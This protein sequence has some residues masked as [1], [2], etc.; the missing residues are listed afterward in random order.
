MMQPKYIA[1]VAIVVVSLVADLGTK[2]MAENRLASRANDYNN[3]LYFDVPEE[4]AGTTMGAFLGEEFAWNTD[5]ELAEIVPRSWI[6]NENGEV[7]RRGSMELTLRGGERIEVRYR[8]VHLIDG[9]F[10]F[11][12]VENRGAAW[13]FLGNVD[14]SVRRPFFITVGIIAVVAIV[15]LYRRTTSEQK[16][17]MGALALIVGGALGNIVDRIRYGYVV[18][19]IKWVPFGY[20][21]PTFNIADVLIVA[22]VIMMFIEAIRDHRREKRARAQSPDGDARTSSGAAS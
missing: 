1:F 17:L 20:E 7:L 8:E 11:R 2:T 6:V 4:S 14:S 5:E 13:G 21:W 3:Y 9:F 16:F 12:Y 18:D 10:G 22:G 15:M 19:F